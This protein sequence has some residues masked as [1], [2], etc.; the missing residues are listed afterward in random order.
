MSLDQIELREDGINLIRF[1]AG[2][3]RARRRQ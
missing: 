1:D 2:K 3:I